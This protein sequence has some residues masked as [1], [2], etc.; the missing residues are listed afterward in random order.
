MDSYV[1]AQPRPGLRLLGG[2][3]PSYI[4][5]MQT[6]GTTRIPKKRSF[7]MTE[8]ISTALRADLVLVP[9]LL[10]YVDQFYFARDHPVKLKLPL[11]QTN[12]PFLGPK[13]HSSL[14]K[15]FTINVKHT[16]IQ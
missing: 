4:Y 12:N 14:R 5:P 7:S 9:P 6:R 3:S 13:T 15:A 16:Y 11:K 2:N 8:S 10:K 1:Q